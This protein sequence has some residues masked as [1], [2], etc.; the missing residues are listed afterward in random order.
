MRQSGRAP[1][2]GGYPS[3]C[4]GDVAGLTPCLA[5]A[6]TAA[7]P[8]AKPA[9]SRGGRRIGGL[10]GGWSWG[11]AEKAS[12]A[13]SDQAE[14]PKADGEQESRDQADRPSDGP[15]LGANAGDGAFQCFDIAFQSGDVGLRV[16][17]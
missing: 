17:A 9:G 2:C 10:P 12:G 1:A 16:R 5:P 11:G 15:K 13:R 14:H 4:A 7:I 3:I 6:A 8:S